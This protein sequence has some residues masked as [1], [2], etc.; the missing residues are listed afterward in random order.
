MSASLALL[1]RALEE[2]GNPRGNGKLPHELFDAVFRISA[3]TDED[4]ENQI[5]QLLMECCA[6]CIEVAAQA[7]N[8]RVLAE[9][10]DGL[11]RKNDGRAVQ[12]AMEHAETH[13]QQETTEML[14]GLGARRRDGGATVLPHLRAALFAG[15]FMALA[16]VSP[17]Y[18]SA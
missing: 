11:P 18:L 17:V 9:F 1:T 7:G 16:C 8:T 6:K 13:G 12:T 3:S 2:A 4:D 5:L 10:L 14:E 15:A